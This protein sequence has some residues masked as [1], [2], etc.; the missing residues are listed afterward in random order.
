M[1]LYKK[2]ESKLLFRL[3]FVGH[4]IPWKR[5]KIGPL[6]IIGM[7]Y[8]CMYLLFASVG[9]VVSLWQGPMKVKKPKKLY[10][11]NPTEPN[12]DEFQYNSG[13]PTGSTLARVG[14]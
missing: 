12:V 2:W 5:L 3:L 1:Y 6:S 8:K 7:L 14:P 11:V 13:V 9:W 10:R 4:D